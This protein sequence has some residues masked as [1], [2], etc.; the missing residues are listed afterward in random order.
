[1]D[2]SFRL[3]GTRRFPTVVAPA[4]APAPASKPAPAVAARPHRFQ[5]FADLLKNNSQLAARPD[6]LAGT[7]H[8]GLTAFLQPPETT[9]TQ[10]AAAK[11]HSV[12]KQVPSP[13]PAPAAPLGQAMIN[14]VHTARP[15]CGCGGSRSG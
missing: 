12:T 9:P 4:P 2:H 6:F 10:A 1:M 14:R 15:G 7:D 8:A 5:E 11:I 3:R 13:P